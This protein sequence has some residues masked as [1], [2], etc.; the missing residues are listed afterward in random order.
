MEQNTQDFL[1]P[2]EY[3]RA[4]AEHYLEHAQ[5]C[6]GM[7]RFNAAQ[8]AIRKVAE[9][10]PESG[11]HRDL[12]RIVSERLD[13]LTHHSNGN[14]QAQ[15]G[16]AT[17]RERA[18]TVLLVDQDERVLTS[19]SH[20]LQREGVETVGA[21]SFEEALEVLATLQPD[22]I[23]SEVNFESGPEGLELFHRI[24]SNGALSTTSFIFFAA[25]LDHDTM[26]AGRRFGVDDFIAKPADDDLV[27]ASIRNCIARRR[28]IPGAS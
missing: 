25:R 3:R 20:S 5:E 13:R 2:D 18:A 11:A 14:G 4:K 16:R 27:V 15:Q 17:A 6:I 23:V 1:T 24:R 28:S 12:E 10:D 19:L 8:E 9:I 21:S 26:V 22:V 7:S